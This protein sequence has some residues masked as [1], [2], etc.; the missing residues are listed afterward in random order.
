MKTLTNKLMIVAA[1]V[2][3][4]AGTASAQSMIVKVPFSFS[5]E[6]SEMP[7]G[8]YTV[9]RLHQSG[10][11][12]IFN[13]RNTDTNRARLIV[14]LVAVDTGAKAYGDTKLVFRCLEGDCRLAQIWTGSLAG[15][16]QLAPPKGGWDG[17]IRVEIKSTN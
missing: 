13:L 7:A 11:Q 9:T 12:P 1:A 6:K 17:R 3:A 8:N 5:V 15:A 16:Y 2:A 14:P 4:A 10:G